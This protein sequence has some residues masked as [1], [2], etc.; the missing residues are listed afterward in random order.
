MY[1]FG[2]ASLRPKYCV[3]EG[4]SG[5]HSVCVCSIHENVKLLIDGANSKSITADS[6]RPL[7]N[8]KDCLD[9]MVCHEKT[10]KCFLSL[11]D[12]CPGVTNVIE[13]LEESFEQKYI[14]NITYKQWVTTERTSLQTLISSADEFVEVLS[15]GL[16]KLLIQSF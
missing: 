2:I 12:R 5:T 11:C 9:C 15:N 6:E 1:F 3:L 16:C 14:E 4:T 7:K 10:S 8:Y 13:Q